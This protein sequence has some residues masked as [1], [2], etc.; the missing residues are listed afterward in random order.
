MNTSSA[1]L[2]FNRVT[3]PSPSLQAA[4]KASN[5]GDAASIYSA[6]VTRENAASVTRENENK[7]MERK[8]SSF[9][10]KN[11]VRKASKSL[12]KLKKEAG[13]PIADSVA[14]QAGVAA[15]HA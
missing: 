3:K 8:R 4:D 1:L 14:M 11:L 15:P 12:M 9:T 7:K 13:S 10:M 2:N 6:S 5:G